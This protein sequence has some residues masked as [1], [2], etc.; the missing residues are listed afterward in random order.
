MHWPS[1]KSIDPHTRTLVKNLRGNNVGLTKVLSVIGSFFGSM[2]DIP[3]NKRSLRSLCADISRDHSEDD[4]RKTC[5][6][7]SEL[8]KKDPNFVDSVLCDKDGKIR[9]TGLQAAPEL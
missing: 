5:D 9:A 6:L 3:F 8:K 7:F 4:V 2:E 1:H